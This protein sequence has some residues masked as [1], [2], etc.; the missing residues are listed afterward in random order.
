MENTIT[1]LAMDE[2]FRFSCS[3]KVSCFN[4]CCRD[5]NQFLTP[6]DILRLKN[7]LK[8]SS[9]VFLERH[10]TQ[11]VGPET[12]LP[13]VTFKMEPATDLRCP[14]VT[15]SGCSVYEDRPAS[16]RTYPLARLA[17]RSKETGEIIEQYALMREPHCHGF[18]QDKTQTAG[19]WVAE[20]GIAEYNEMNDLLMEIIGLKQRLHPTPLDIKSSH[21]F[22]LACYDIDAFRS[23][24]FEKG[25]LEESGV[26]MEP[27]VAD[28]AKTDD[29]ALL[30][31]SLAW[32]RQTLFGS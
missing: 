30:R 18:D 27:S 20:Q 3:E 4:E 7:R 5:L 6:Y 17:Y 29:T 12:G 23:Q 14:F 2:P 31:L 8:L 21:M 26:E 15:P 19:E 11:H 9:G 28:A 10:T 22:H 25:V 24:I 32:L 1:P 16:C 13:V